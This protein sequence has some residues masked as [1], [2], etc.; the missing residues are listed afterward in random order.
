[1]T[2]VD[3]NFIAHY[4]EKTSTANE[5][6]YMNSTGNDLEIALKNNLTNTNILTVEKKNSK[7]QMKFEN[8]DGSFVFIA[9]VEF[10]CDY[11]E[12]LDCRKERAKIVEDRKSTKDLYE[13]YIP[14]CTGPND[15]LYNATQCHPLSGICWCAEPSGAVIAGSSKPKDEIRC[16]PESIKKIAIVK[17]QP[18]IRAQSQKSSGCHIRKM[19]KFLRLHLNAL[20]LHC[21]EGGHCLDS[22][23]EKA[24]LHEVALKKF[25]ELDINENKELTKNEWKRYRKMLIQEQVFSSTRK[26]AKLFMRFCDVNNNRRISKEEWINCTVRSSSIV[27]HR[28]MRFTN[29]F[30]DV[31]RSEN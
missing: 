19:K 26:C 6:R 13:V 3:G 17:A 10:C 14:S 11:Y 21:F 5:V 18:V 20:R 23:N 31:L 2:T 4:R 29:P 25:S 22:K 30:L 27:Y 9:V 28:L 15:S 7:K 12:E 24:D 8:D 1:M 16:D